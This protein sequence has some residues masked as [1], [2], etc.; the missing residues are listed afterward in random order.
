MTEPVVKLALDYM[1]KSVITGTHIPLDIFE[2]C[3]PFLELTQEG[4]G[5]IEEFYELLDN[6]HDEFIFENL[7]NYM[8]DIA[9]TGTYFGAHPG[10]GS[11]FGFWHDNEF[12]EV[13]DN[14]NG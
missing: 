1:D 9:P 5:L 3:K 6:E 10:D 7:F 4:E 8:N 14:C 2:A 11:D 12:E 13:E